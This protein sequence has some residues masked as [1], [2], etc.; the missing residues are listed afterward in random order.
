MCSSRGSIAVLV[1]TC[2]GSLAWFSSSR[3]EA[4]RQDLSTR[5][6]PIAGATTPIRT[7]ESLRLLSL[8]NTTITSADV[9]T[10]STGESA[11]RVT[12]SVSRAPAAPHAV[13]VF[14]RLPLADWNGRFL[15]LGGDGFTGGDAGATGR[16]L[17]ARFASATTDGGHQT[18]GASF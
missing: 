18:P 10:N 12:A 3:V 17:A 8:P 16:P 6:R 14:V 2:L 15:G 4:A 5:L 13:T 11:C 1:A 7:C 9:Q